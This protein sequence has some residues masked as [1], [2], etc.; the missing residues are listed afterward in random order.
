MKVVDLYNTYKDNYKEY[1]IFIKIGNFYET[2]NNDAYI[3][4]TLMNY[5][6]KNLS[7]TIRVGFPI[8]SLVKVLDKLNNSKVNYIVIEKEEIYKISI[9]KKF[10]DNKYLNYD[11]NRLIRINNIYSKILN[12]NNDILDRIEQIIWK[13]NY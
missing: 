2:Y 1:V 5:K 7:E 10:R 4:S 9:K 13:I 11:N 3:I 6:V 12:C 8:N